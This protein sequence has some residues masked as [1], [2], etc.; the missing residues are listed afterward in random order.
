MSC[1]EIMLKGC[2]AMELIKEIKETNN[3]KEE[4]KENMYNCL[5]SYQNDQLKKQLKEFQE[6][7]KAL[8]EK[9]ELIL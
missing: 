9:L 3:L 8:E 7:T 2:M 4:I 6:K 5:Y 1:S